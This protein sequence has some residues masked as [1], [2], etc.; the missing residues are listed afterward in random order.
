MK[1]IITISS[2]LL[3][4]QVQSQEIIGKWK[5]IDDETGKQKSIVE[6]YVKEGE[7]YGKI[8]ELFRSPEEDQDP[9]CDK[10]EDDRKDQRVIGMEILRKMVKDDD[11]WEDGE[12][13]DPKDGKIYDCKMWIDED[14]PDVLNVRGY[15][16]F[17]YRT[18][19]WHR[20]K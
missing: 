2:L 3:L 19:Q 11:K 7:V 20:I 10:C 12:I 8:L 15:I 1:Y 6:I 5:T 14:N 4:L 18:Q 17:L 13:C 16:L 9:Y